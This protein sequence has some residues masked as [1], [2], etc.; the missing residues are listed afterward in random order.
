MII[1]WAE[2]YSNFYKDSSSRILEVK[3]ERE[4][5]GDREI[6]ST[7]GTDVSLLARGFE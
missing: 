7:Q 5:I 1:L 2:S 3:L 4:D 6:S